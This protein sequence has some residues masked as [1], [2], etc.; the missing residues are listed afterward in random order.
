MPMEGLPHRR[1]CGCEWCVE[2]REEEMREMM[3]KRKRWWWRILIRDEEVVA[4]VLQGYSLLLAS[5]G[6]GRSGSAAKVSGQVTLVKRR[7]AV[8][9]AEEEEEVLPH[10]WIGAKWDVP[11][12]FGREDAARKWELPSEV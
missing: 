11:D 10:Q 8:D 1:T 12:L 6:C 7:W 2:A 5:K 3:E 9:V 4:E